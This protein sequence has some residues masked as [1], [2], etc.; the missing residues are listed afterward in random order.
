MRVVPMEAISADLKVATLTTK[1]V[2]GVGR[3]IGQRSP[4]DNHSFYRPV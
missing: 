3:M 4:I 2:P 1:S